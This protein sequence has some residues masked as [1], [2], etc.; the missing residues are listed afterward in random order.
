MCV[1][2]VVTFL[3]F[4]LFCMCELLCPDVILSTMC[5]HSALGVK[6]GIGSPKLDD[7]QHNVAVGNRTQVYCKSNKQVG[8]LFLVPHLLRQ[9]SIREESPNF[10]KTWFPRIT[11]LGHG[12]AEAGIQFQT[13]IA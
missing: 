12:S 4:I 7:W 13:P 1:G 5:M 8:L 10:S 9:F 3:R 6:E 11:W 2:V